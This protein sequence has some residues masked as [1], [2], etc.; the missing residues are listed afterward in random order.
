L[1]FPAKWIA[2]AN[3]KREK[4]DS[5]KKAH[6]EVKHRVATS[7]NSDKVRWKFHCPRMCQQKPNGSL[8]KKTFDGKICKSCGY[9]KQA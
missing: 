1:D 3:K 2:D 4:K 6:F 9:K 8:G 5:P 7:L